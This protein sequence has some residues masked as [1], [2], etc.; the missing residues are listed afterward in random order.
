[1]TTLLDVSA[2]TVRFGGVTAVN[3]VSFSLNKGELLGF[4]GP[5]GAGKTTMMR[6]IT[7]VVTPTEGEIRLLGKILTKLP[8]HQRVRLGLGFSQQLVK[9]FRNMTVL[10]NVAL[11]AG[12]RHTASPFSALFRMK[13]QREKEQAAQLLAQVGIADAAEADPSNLPLGYLKRLEVARALALKP[14]LLLLDEPLAGLNHAEAH[15]LADMIVALNQA[16]Q[17]IILIEHNL[18][19]VM[20]I[21]SR[22]I[23]QDNGNKIG[24]G[25]PEAVMNTSV[26]RAAYLGEGNGHAAA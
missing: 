25:D 16:G 5:N 18:G 2:V 9:P 7:G 15:K 22:L 10:E 14:S 13:R 19:E 3:G 11:A 8:V 6:A 24:E 4:I 26:V 17:S 20:R 1:M 12:S 23:V 21:C